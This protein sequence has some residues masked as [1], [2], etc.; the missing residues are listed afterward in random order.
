MPFVSC[1][2]FT[3]SRRI[4]LKYPAVFTGDSLLQTFFGGQGD[5]AKNDC[6]D[7]GREIKDVSVFNA[8]ELELSDDYANSRIAEIHL[9]AA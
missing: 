8:E 6:L 1:H 7:D 3:V 4:T 9:H 2:F 5:P